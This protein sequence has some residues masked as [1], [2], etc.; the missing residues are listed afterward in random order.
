MAPKSPAKRR[1]HCISSII[2]ILSELKNKV[3][4]FLVC[5]PY[6]ICIPKTYTLREIIRDTIIREMETQ[7]SQD[8]R[9]EKNKNVLG[10]S[11]HIHTPSRSEQKLQNITKLQDI[12]GFLC[13]WDG[14][15]PGLFWG[16]GG[17]Q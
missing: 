17:C 5:P 10:G 1:N 16:G 15:A 13:S 12:E 7:Q 6:R 11:P 14:L 2:L 8:P 4:Y 9:R 3:L